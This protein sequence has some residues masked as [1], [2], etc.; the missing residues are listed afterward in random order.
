MIVGETFSREEE[1]RGRPFVGASGHLLNQILAM[2]GIE[3]DACYLTNVFMQRPPGNDA[4]FFCGP[5]AQAIPDFPALYPAKY[6]RKEYQFEL[7]RL[8]AEIKLHRPNLILAL[9]GT[10][11]WFL[12]KDRRISKLR[13]AAVT[14]RFGTKVLATY[15]PAAVLRD[16]SLRPIFIADVD[17]ASREM[18]FSELRR[19]QRYIH[20]EPSLDDLQTFYSQFIAPA[21]ALSIDVETIGNQITCLGLAPSAERALVIPFYDPTKPDG[22]YWPTRDQEIEAWKFVARVIAEARPNIGQN[23]TYDAKFFWRSYGIPV[24]G[25]SGGDDTMLLHHALQ[26]ELQKG[27][28]FLGT[29]YTDE[30][31]WKLERKVSTIKREE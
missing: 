19:P 5:K 24:L 3:R 1:E 23:F 14:S 18:Q 30:A 2:A 8:G 20:I 17:K 6:V 27:L 10:A 22:N 25:M 9:G 21:S 7:D 4:G 11:T 16:Y 12:L 15:H 13:G 31:P 26:P 28:A 29:I